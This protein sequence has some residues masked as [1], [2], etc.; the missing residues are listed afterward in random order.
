MDSVS[1]PTDRDQFLCEQIG[2]AGRLLERGFVPVPLL[3]REKKPAIP[4]WQK[5]TRQDVEARLQELFGKPCNIGVLLGDPS[6]GL[7]DIDL[8]CPEAV[9][10][11]PL[12][13]PTGMTWGRPSQ[14]GRT[15][16]GYLV[17]TPPQKSSTSYSDLEGHRLLE[18]RSTDGQTLLWG[19]Y[20]EGEEVGGSPL[21]EPA[22]LAWR[23]LEEKVQQLAAA[24]L[25]AGYWREGCRHE[26]ALAV[27]SGLLRAGWSVEQ[28]QRFMR[29][30]L[31]AAGDTEVEDRLRAVEDTAEKIRRG[32]AVTGW[33]TL[34]ERIGSDVA[35]KVRQWL[36]VPSSSAEKQP[37]SAA[38]ILVEIGLNYEL[39]HD[40]SERGYATI[41]RV[42]L[43]IRSKSFRS[44]L[45]R[46]FRE[47]TGKVPS[48]EAMTN[49]L[50]AIEAEALDG[51]ESTPHT[52]VAFHDDRI[53]YHLADE[54][55]TVIEISPEGWRECQR[56]P[57][58]FVRRSGLLALPRPQRDGSLEEWRPLL[59]CPDDD[60][61]TLLKGWITAAASGIGPFPALVLTGEQGSA[62]STT[63]RM[64]KALIDPADPLLRS[65]PREARD[66]MLSAVRQHLL[67][68]DNLSHLSPWLSD[69]LCGLV[70]GR[71]F[72]TR[73]L[74][75]DEE[76]VVFTA[77]RPLILNGITDF[78]TRPDMMDRSVFLRHPPIP[79]E[80][81]REERE[82]WERFEA[83]RPR[84]LG[85]LFDRLCGM[86]RE[87]PRVELP[88]KPRMADFAVIAVAAERGAGE[89]ECFL[90]AYGLVQ[91]QAEAEMVEEDPVGAALLRWKPPQNPWE[92]T[93][94]ELLTALTDSLPEE[95]RK[96]PGWPTNPRKLSASLKR[97]S[98]ILR[99]LGIVYEPIGRTGSGKACRP[100]HRIRWVADP[101]SEGSDVQ[102]VQ[103]VQPPQETQGESAAH[104]SAHSPEQGSNVQ[105][106]VQQETPSKPRDS[107]CAAH[108]ARS[109]PAFSG[110]S[111]C[112][113]TESP[114]PEAHTDSP[115][116]EWVTTPLGIE[117]LAAQSQGEADLAGEVGF[118][119]TL[120]P[121][122]PLACPDGANGAEWI[123]TPEGVADLSRRLEGADRVAVDIETT[124]LDPVFHMQ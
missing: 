31:E 123:T 36:D 26:L 117:E 65:E 105:N 59:N 18:V 42:S 27:S 2:I 78:V 100:R 120:P 85:A 104:S 48:G 5:L 76:E 8:D 39:W 112:P 62:K 115:P 4:E 14:G 114:V 87:R 67:V 57:V 82:L 91:A 109:S 34:A 102:N 35:G 54:A 44:R 74:Y 7:I 63:A 17:D 124:G 83:L 110:G 38:D 77:M 33:P 10:A 22:R 84:L 116:A 96:T 86:L 3:F 90:A 89:P 113:A 122:V 61:W 29:A 94:K 20:P 15:H 72:A 70:T 107:A 111:G 41:G 108:S 46:T 99:K 97:L 12:L 13:P 92:G 64:L 56:P 1:H 121:P 66:L 73:E 11:A 24:A 52:R 71:G 9:R 19:E 16:Y 53:Y 40:A 118:S 93:M 23:E 25:L 119:D 81:R 37:R 103:N 106:N 32:E 49:A 50:T 58:R 30:V 98:P 101:T 51:P 95:E 55:D 6:G 79:G 75:S 21:G 80:R 43:P 88:C 68:F 28:V 45:L 47:Q 69:A 60:S